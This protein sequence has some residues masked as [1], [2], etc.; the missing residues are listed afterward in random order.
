[1]NEVVEL[2]NTFNLKP[3][4]RNF[5]I[6]EDQYQFEKKDVIDLIMQLLGGS[7]MK[8]LYIQTKSKN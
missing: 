4:I 7:V 1:M 3:K 2:N 6:S 5:L 8:K